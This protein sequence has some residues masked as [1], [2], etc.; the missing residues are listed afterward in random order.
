MNSIRF[1]NNVTNKLVADD[2]S[3]NS[4]TPPIK[5]PDQ[6][7]PTATSRALA[8]IHLA[9]YNVIRIAN[10]NAPILG[11]GAPSANVPSVPATLKVDAA[12]GAAAAAVATA[13][14][15]KHAA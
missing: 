10:G 4:A 11:I 3:Y 12:I 5:K 9:M 8:I 15:S 6:P 1:W 2:Y 14:Y 7:G 13:L